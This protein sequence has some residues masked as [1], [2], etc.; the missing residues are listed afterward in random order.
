MLFNSVEFICL[1]LPVALAGF[2]FFGAWLKRAQW[3]ILWLCG[4]SLVFYA[5]WNVAFV[6]LLVISLVFNYSVG[7][8][9]T[10]YPSRWLLAFGLGTNILVLGWFKYSGFLAEAANAAFD[11]GL[12]IPHVILPLAISFYTFQK[13]AYLVDSHEGITRGTSFPH[14]ALFVLFFPQLIA[15]PIVHHKEII[16]QFRQPGI[17][18]PDPQMI[19]IGLTAF[20]IG[21][22]KKVAL[23]DAFDPIADATFMTAAGGSIPT[24]ANAWTGGLAFTLQLYFDFSGYSDMALGLGFMFGLRLPVNFASPFKSAS[25]IEFWARWHMT[26]SRF[27]T[28]YLY[29]P[30]VKALTT[31]RMKSGKPLLRRSAPAIGPFFILL[32]TPTLLTMT[33]AGIWHGAGWQFLAFG[34]LHG[35]Y[36]SINHAWRIFRPA[37]PRIEDLRRRFGLPFRVLAVAITFVA[38]CVSLVFFRATSLSEAITLVAGMAGLQPLMALDEVHPATNK[39]DVLLVLIGLAIVWSLP[40]TVQWLGITG[41]EPPDARNRSHAWL[42]LHW[43]WRPTILQG[44][45]VGSIACLTMIVAFSVAPSEFLYFTF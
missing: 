17:Y 4:M 10:Q 30:I 28:A 19:M 13:I 21:L 35:T 9:L 11:V 3:A 41:A 26:L 16:H 23:A 39:Q 37:G 15:G 43:R 7:R 42:P 2:F 14:Y 29:N 33:L 38:V 44:V 24:L 31:R 12:P 6:P 1:F 22:Y 5:Q 36:L 18:R 40:S 8:A 20:F 25:I 27:L 34:V 32:I 45:I